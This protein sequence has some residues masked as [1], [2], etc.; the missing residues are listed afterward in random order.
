MRAMHLAA[1]RALEDSEHSLPD[2][3]V[4][5]FSRCACVCVCFWVSVFLVLQKAPIGVENAL[6]CLTVHR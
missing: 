1:V 2:C 6:S 4:G 3:H 5:V